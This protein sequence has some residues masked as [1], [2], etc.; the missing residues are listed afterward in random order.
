MFELKPCWRC[1]GT[2]AP[3]PFARLT[4]TELLA[5]SFYVTP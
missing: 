1:L 3:E 2:E 4:D 5:P